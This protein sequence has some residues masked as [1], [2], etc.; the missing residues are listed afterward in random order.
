M[1]CDPLD[2]NRLYY[3]FSQFLKERFG[4]RVH[5]LSLHAGFSCPN[6]DGT[7]DSCGCIFC[8]NASFSHFVDKKNISL[9][10][11]ISSSMEFARRRFKAKKFIAYF[12]SFSG[13]YDTPEALEKAY[14]VIKKFKDIVGL[15]ISTRPDTIDNDKLDVIESFTKDYMVWIE[16]GLQTVHNKSLSF[17]KRNHTFED[18]LKAI[19]LTKNR[20]ILIAAHLILGLPTE[21]KQDM[22]ITAKKIQSLPISG[23]KFHC[24]HVVKDTGLVP[25]YNKGNISL[26]SL[27]QYVD[28][29]CDFL[30]NI[31]E[32]VVI[33][34]VISDAHPK[35]LLAPLWIN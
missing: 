34:R 23:V 1:T 28:I 29:L 14:G 20:N 6:I 32:D 8:N 19:E 27:N 5:R 7:L 33:L 22:L 2:M 4:C 15:S 31:A 25:L 17:L 24:L 18:F 35:H 16:Y 10:E 13:T 30:E 3:S 12:Q 26:L 11:Q 21:S 9:E